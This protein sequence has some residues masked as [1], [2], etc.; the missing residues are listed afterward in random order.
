MDAYRTS[1]LP[2]SCRDRRSSGYYS[3]SRSTFSANAEEVGVLFRN[4]SRRSNDSSRKPSLDEDED[5]LHQHDKSQTAENTL[6]FRLFDSQMPSTY[7]GRSKLQGKMAEEC[8]KS[9]ENPATPPNGK[10]IS[11]R[12]LWYH[13]VWK[14]RLYY[15]NYSDSF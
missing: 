5:N 4:G 7:H 11:G 10:P 3:P 13:D 2:V 6:I 12:F 14:G 9:I 15:I 1:T 8:L